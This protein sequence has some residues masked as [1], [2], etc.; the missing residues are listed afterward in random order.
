MATAETEF[1]SFKGD[2]GKTTHSYV[3]PVVAGSCVG[4][5]VQRVTEHGA[6]VDRRGNPIRRYQSGET[7]EGE[8][9]PRWEGG[10][11]IVDR[12]TITTLRTE[13][14][15]KPEPAGKR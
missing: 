1:R 11:R 3:T 15:A 7:V 5:C 10:K 8:I 6:T 12:W 14:P 13:A 9:E 4:D 2:D